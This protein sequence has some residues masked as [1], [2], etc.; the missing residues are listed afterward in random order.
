MTDAYRK[1]IAGIVEGQVKNFIDGH[2]D[3]LN[4]VLWFKKS[5]D[6]KKTLTNSISKRIIS[7]LTSED[8]MNKIRIALVDGLLPEQQGTE[9]SLGTVTEAA[10]VPTLPDHKYDPGPYGVCKR[11]G[12]QGHWSNSIKHE[13]YDDK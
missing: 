7:D 13:G 6:R 8:T 4:C 10:P 11:C 5:Q 12:S 1:I 3:I 2:P 9:S